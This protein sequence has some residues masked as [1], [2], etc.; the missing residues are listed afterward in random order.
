ML[1]DRCDALSL[2]VIYYSLPV[3]C[4]CVRNKEPNVAEPNVAE[5]PILLVSMEIV[6]IKVIV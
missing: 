4:M 5:H 2:C 1:S 3:V 6:V